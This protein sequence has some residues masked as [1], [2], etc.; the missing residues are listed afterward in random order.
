MNPV[1]N[2]GPEFVTSKLLVEEGGVL[3]ITTNQLSATDIDTPHALLK[4]ALIKAPEYGTLQND[5]RTVKEKQ[6]FVIEDLQK[7]RIR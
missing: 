6:Y 3:G 5:G 7:K 1:N 4:F 2:H